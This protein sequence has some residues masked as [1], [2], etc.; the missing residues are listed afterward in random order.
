MVD[1]LRA[2][3]LIVSFV[4]LAAFGWLYYFANKDAVYRAVL[5]RV[6]SGLVQIHAQF[7]GDPG[8]KN[9]DAL[10]WSHERGRRVHF[11]VWR[12]RSS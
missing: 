3:L 9:P 1:K 5:E 4:A 8:W 7:R 6:I 12:S 10:A 2:L 11:G